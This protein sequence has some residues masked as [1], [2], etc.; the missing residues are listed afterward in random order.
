LLPAQ[1]ET[2]DRASVANS[3][4]TTRLIA[5]LLEYP[6][7]DKR[8]HGALAM[9]SAGDADQQCWGTNAPRPCRAPRV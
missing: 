4:P 6:H 1:A 2:P 3:H 7:A 8:C 5:D 9:T